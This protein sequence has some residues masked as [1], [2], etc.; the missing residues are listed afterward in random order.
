MAKQKKNKN[1]V[2]FVGSRIGGKNISALIHLLDL[3]RKKI[4]GV[5]ITPEGSI[6]TEQAHQN[7][8]SKLF[9]RIKD[10]VETIPVENGGHFKTEFNFG[11]ESGIAKA[12]IAINLVEK[13]YQYEI[14]ER[15][16]KK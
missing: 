3:H 4:D 1:I 6:R 14:K 9:L 12:L 5:L 13:M 8:I 15:S 11:F 7:D 2:N 10:V 16:E